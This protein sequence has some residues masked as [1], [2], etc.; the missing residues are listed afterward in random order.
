MNTAEIALVQT[1]FRRLLPAL[2][3]VGVLFYARLLELDPVL[4]LALDGEAVA[5][6][7]RLVQ[8]VALTVNGLNHPETLAPVVRR[9]GR[10]CADIFQDHVRVETIG[11]ALLWA[12]EAAAREPFAVE[13]RQA[14]AKA[15][16]FLANLLRAGADE[17]AVAA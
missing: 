17:A 4:R 8:W 6:N 14:W 11:A 16:G 10:S 3:R 12:L 1:S 2:D 5:R 13:T 7:R 9:A 15:Y